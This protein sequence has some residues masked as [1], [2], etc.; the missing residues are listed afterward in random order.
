[1]NILFV[2]Q[3]FPSQYRHILQVLS[4]TRGHRLI[5]LGIEP[6]EYKLPDGIEHLRY[7]LLRGNSAEIHPL[8]L[9]TETKV[10][11]A[12][13]CAL[14]ADRLK[15]Q[16]FIPD[17]ICAHPGWGEA[18]FLSQIWPGTPTIFY[19]EFFYNTSGFDCDF[20]PEIQ[21]ISEWAERAKIQM[22][23]AN[24]LL[25]LQ[26][27]NWNIS[28]TH[29]QRSSFPKEFQSC[30]SVMHDGIDTN[31]AKPATKPLSLRLPNGM[32]LQTGMPVVTFVN[33]RLEPYRGCHTMIRAIPELQQLHPEAQLVI[34]GETTGVSYGAS[35]PEGEWRE[36]FLREI[37]GQYDPGKVHFVGRVSHEHY[38]NLLKLSA[39][40]VYLTY[41]FVLGWSLL[42]AMACGCAVVGSSTAPVMEVIEHG[43]NGLLVDFFQ[44]KELATSI[45]ELLNNRELAAA[46]GTQARQTILKDY[47]LEQCVPRHLALMQ[48]VA[49]GS[50]PR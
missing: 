35:C 38:L 49:N 20:D 3:N 43:R 10:L 12:E 13:A 32:Q 18:L 8:V 24:L 22:K 11:R 30:I 28:P 29:F 7:P 16:G 31:K 40:H 25:S 39:C 48:L 14:A 2:H 42:E 5:G 26:C 9:E 4:R 36:Y 44:P 34:V 21:G 27:A 15:Q 33:R 46:L 23:N 19:Q 47:S 37:E 41:P 50:L 17:L 1:M 45:A 6:L